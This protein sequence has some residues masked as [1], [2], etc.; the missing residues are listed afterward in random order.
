MSWE[1][2]IYLRASSFGWLVKNIHSLLRKYNPEDYA[3]FNTAWG[4]SYGNLT[5][6]QIICP[7]EEEIRIL[8]ERADDLE[9]Q[10]KK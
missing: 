4:D 10:L 1:L 9:K 8:R 5:R 6:S 3:S 2:K 7:V